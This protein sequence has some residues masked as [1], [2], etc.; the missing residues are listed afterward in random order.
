MSKDIMFMLEDNNIMGQPVY[1]RWEKALWYQRFLG[2]FFKRYKMR[3]ID[4]K[5]FALNKTI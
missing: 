3:F 5:G 4:Y 2:F 1:D